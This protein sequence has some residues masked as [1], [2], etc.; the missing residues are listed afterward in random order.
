[1]RALIVIVALFVTSNV[2]ASNG[3]ELFVIEK[4]DKT[5]LNTLPGYWQRPDEISE[6][7]TLSHRVKIAGNQLQVATRCK[8]QDE[9]LY[10][11]VVVPIKISA[12]TIQ[13][14][15]G[16]ASGTNSEK[17]SCNVSIGQTSPMKYIIRQGFLYFD[18]QLA[19]EKIHNL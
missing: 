2:L 15:K 3:S 5:N 7:V 11:T 6:G 9:V 4:S 18:G 8:L 19:L 1:M 13:I 16:A 10:S 12:T 14:L 17:L